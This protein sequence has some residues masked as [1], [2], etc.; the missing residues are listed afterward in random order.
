MKFNYFQCP[1]TPMKC[2][3]R[4]FV[5]KSWFKIKSRKQRLAGSLI[6]VDAPAQVGSCR[7]F[8]TAI[9]TVVYNLW[10]NNYIMLKLLFPISLSF[11]FA[12]NNLLHRCASSLSPHCLCLLLCAFVSHLLFGLAGDIIS[13]KQFNSTLVLSFCAREMSCRCIFR[14]IIY[15]F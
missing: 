8:T 6:F 12:Q 4:R 10:H 14:L 11:A 2:K 3:H 15:Y 9:D 7:N 1:L 5:K 13:P